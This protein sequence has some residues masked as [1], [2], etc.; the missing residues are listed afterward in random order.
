[1]RL[2]FK[3]RLL[4]LPTNIKHGWKSMAGTNFLAD[5]NIATITKAKGFIVQSPGPNVI[6]LFVDVIYECSK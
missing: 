1:M 6:K 5:C 3:G 2:Y 4:A